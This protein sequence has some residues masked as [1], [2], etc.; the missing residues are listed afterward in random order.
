MATTRSFRRR[1][2]LVNRPYQLQFVSRVLF[3]TTVALAS[4]LVALAFLWKILYRPGLERQAY[5]IAAC[6]GVAVTL[7]I[8]LLI[9]IPIIYYLGVRQSHQVIG[10]LQR[11][12]QALEAIGAGDFSQRLDLRPGDALKDLAKAINRM[13]ESLHKRSSKSSHP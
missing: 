3:V 12:A 5:L 8:Q 10:P 6:I 4:S 9:S 13:A 7:L 2:Y 1:R 11:I